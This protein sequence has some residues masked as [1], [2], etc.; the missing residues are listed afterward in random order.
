M[1]QYSDV[2]PEF[3]SKDELKKSK[4]KPIPVPVLEHGIPQ[5]LKDLKQWVCWRYALT[6]KAEW[7]KVPYDAALDKR[8]SSTNPETWRSFSTAIAEYKNRNRPY[9]YDGI[10]FVFKEGDTLT[11]VDIDSCRDKNG[12]VSPEAAELIKKFGTYSELSPS[13]MGFKCF[14]KVKPEVVANFRTK[15]GDYEAYNHGRYF[16]VTGHVLEQTEIRDATPEFEDFA[17]AKLGER[18]D[19]PTNEAGEEIEPQEEMLMSEA[20]YNFRLNRAMDDIKFSTH[21]LEFDPTRHSEN[22]ARLV[23]KAVFYFGPD[24]GAVT[25]AV[26]DSAQWCQPWSTGKWDRLGTKEF[27]DGLAHTQDYYKLPRGWDAPDLSAK[28]DEHMRKAKEKARAEVTD[29]IMKLKERSL[30]EIVECGTEL[31][32]EGLPLDPT[33]KLIIS[34]KPRI[35]ILSLEDLLNL[36]DPEWLIDQHFHKGTLSVLYG[37]P[38]SYKSFV[39]LDMALSIAAGIPFLD[40]FDT[41]T[42]PVLYI[43]GEGSGGLKRRSMAWFGEKNDGEIPTAFGL[44]RQRVDLSGTQHGIKDERKNNWKAVL[45]SVRNSHIGIP[46]LVVIDTMARAFTGDENSSQDVGRFVEVTDAIREDLGA[47]VLVVHHTGKDAGRGARGSSA[48]LGAADSMFLVEKHA[49]GADMKNEK[50]KDAPELAPYGILKREVE[51]YPKAPRPHDRCSLVFDRTDATARKTQFVEKKDDRV[52][53]CGYIM[54]GIQEGKGTQDSIAEYV[55]N[56]WGKNDPDRPG[57]NKVKNVVREMHL[58][59]VLKYDNSS[60]R[61][62]TDLAGKTRLAEFLA[63]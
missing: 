53:I 34:A 54:H 58:A 19:E 36:P 39:A 30:V 50:Q 24:F 48:L 49:S 40:S 14:M 3:N 32:T 46:S 28:L 44:V 56:H 42:G 5:E 12:T 33:A 55:Q 41:T 16:T 57:V 51:V 60:Q 20:E 59:N 13:A 63:K 62:S 1:H 4:T 52:K 37:A 61:Y 15:V 45:D 31:P 2:L 26:R 11:G 17:K 25:K 6:N 43:A 23:F 10:G 18:K 27:K 38:G 9:P 29:E 21:Y 35:E 8:A 47:S 22:V 7:S